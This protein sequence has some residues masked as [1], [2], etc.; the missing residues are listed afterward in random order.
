M[1]ENAPNESP[2]RHQLPFMICPDELASAGLPST[3]SVR[4]R[5]TSVKECGSG[6]LVLLD[7]VP[8]VPDGGPGDDMK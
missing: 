4:H 5:L 6:K 1:A 3:R 7:V 2:L 8:C